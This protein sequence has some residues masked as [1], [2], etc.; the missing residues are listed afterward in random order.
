MEK[1]VTVSILGVGAR[2][3]TVYGPTI[4]ANKKFKI[5]A[6]CDIRKERLDRFG[7]EWDIPDDMRFL[8]EKE[9]FEKKRSDLIIIATQDKDHVRMGIKAMQLGY[10]VLMEKPISPYKDELFALIEAQKKYNKKVMICHVLRYAPAF[11]K[12]KQL[13]DNG[14]IGQLRLIESVE[15]VAYWHQAHSFVRGNWRKEEETSPMIMAKCCHDLDLLQYYA[16][17]KCDTIFSVG[18]LSYFNSENKPSDASERCISCKYINSCPYSAENI[19]VKRWK[20]KGMPKDGWPFNIVCNKVPLTEH[21]IRNSYSQ[22][23]YGKCV[24]ACDNDVVDNQTTTILFKNGVK[25]NLI[26]TGFTSDIGR[27]MCFYGTTGNIKFDEAN[28]LL[29]IETFGQ[30]KKTLKISELVD[31]KTVNSYGHG[32]GDYVMLKDLYEMVT[33][34]TECGTSLEN[35]IESHLMALAAEESRKSGKVIKLH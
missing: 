31:D 4:F 13:L 8:D 20:E 25:A 34:G 3:G 5:V 23:Q 27:V 15:Q 29:S 24:F 33:S 35:S 16:N 12:V 26:M 14:E 30:P 18:N 11:V 28:D 2:G 19:Y 9:F 22:N 7:F 6:L 17:S 21:D 10:D 32:G 1:I